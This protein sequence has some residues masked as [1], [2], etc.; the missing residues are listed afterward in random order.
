MILSKTLSKII[1]QGTQYEER[2][3]GIRGGQLGFYQN[4]KK[5]LE[6]EWKSQKWFC[7]EDGGE[8][9]WRLVMFSLFTVIY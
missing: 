5:M 7:Q 1:F 6:N 2:R 4:R 9:R 3:K 8:S